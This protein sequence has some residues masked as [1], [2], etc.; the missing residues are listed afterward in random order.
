LSDE[1]EK[2]LLGHIFGDTLI[3]AHAKTEAKDEAS[4]PFVDSCHR[5]P[6]S[7]RYPAD[8]A[9]IIL[10]CGCFV[11]IRISRHYHPMNG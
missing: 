9:Q 1:R 3:V 4:M 6:I 11:E 2:N 8:K 10:V 7:I 5:I